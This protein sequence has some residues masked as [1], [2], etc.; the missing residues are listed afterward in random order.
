MPALAALL[1]AS[2]A[3]AAGP[4]DYG[5]GSFP[6]ELK[7]VRREKR[8]A[9]GY[10]EYEL[11]FPSPLNSGVAAN[12]TVRGH[13]LV[14]AGPGPFPAVLVLP[15]MAAPNVWIESWFVERLVKDRFAVLWLEMPYQFQRR[16]HP[17]Q[18]SGQV[19]LARTAKRLA[20][21]F[22]QSALD[23]RRAVAWLEKRPE[24]DARR[25]GVFGV[26]LG[27]LVGSAVYSVEPRLAHAVFLL[28]GADF[29]RLV[30]ESA[31]TGPFLA[32]AGITGEELRRSWKGL[33]PLE[34]K[35]GNRGKKAL[36]INAGWDRVI[37]KTAALSLREAFPDARQIWVPFGHYSSI[38]HLFWVPG[39]VSRDFSAN[40]NTKR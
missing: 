22:R 29:P 28:G 14:P 16:A 8:F 12:D 7:E 27:A 21:N 17:S 6:A 25:L 9:R 1:L 35:E 38:V 37:P 26:S 20:F 15:V 31:M 24:V 18:P 23:A 30:A 11:S 2:A 36:L 19:F 4:L 32:K 10:T 5:G 34:R 33:D 39:L 40:F 13:F 3:L